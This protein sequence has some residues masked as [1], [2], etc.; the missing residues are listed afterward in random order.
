MSE[1]G[2]EPVLEQSKWRWLRWHRLRAL[3]NSTAARLTILIPL[4]GYLVVFNDKVVAYLELSARIFGQ[5]AAA[6]SLDKLLTIYIG[7]VCVALASAIFALCCPLEV[8]KYASAEEYIAGEEPFMSERG[9]GMLEARL[10]RGDELARALLRGYQDWNNSRPTTNSL[11][12]LRRRGQRLFR[13]EMNLY[14]EMQDRSRPIAQC[15][16]ALFYAVGFVALLFPSASVFLRVM[17]VLIRNLGL[18]S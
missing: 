5:A 10:K 13:I 1:E 3:G 7:L 8:K 15:L 14:Y 12:E 17:Q 9:E 4:I 2:E 6:G 18:V 16:A 11:E